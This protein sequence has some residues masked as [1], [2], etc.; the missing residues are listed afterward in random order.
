MTPLHASGR[1]PEHRLRRLGCGLLL[2]LAFLV[3]ARMPAQAPGRRPRGQGEFRPPTPAF[4][5]DVPAHDAD[6]L[7]A[8]PTD[9]SVV[10]SLRV[11][12][13]GDVVV[14]HRPQGHPN[15]TRAVARG[16]EPW[17]PCEILL[18]GLA[19]NVRHE[20][21]V[22]LAAQGAEPR[23]VAEGGFHT[24]R[25]RGSPFA[26][27]VQADSH[28]DF[29]IL[30]DRYARSL[31][32]AV[33]SRPDFHVDLGDTFM[34]DKHA[35]HEDA[36]PM[37]QAQRYWLGIV[38]RHAPVFLV[39]GNHD[40]ESPGR[41]GDGDAMR[42][43][44]HGW[45]T[46]HFPNPIPN[47]FYSGNTQRHPRMGWP[48]DYYAW[49][50]G[51]AL[52]VALDPFW[53]S[54]RPGRGASDGWARTLGRDQYEWLRGLLATNGSAHVF[55]FIH[56]LVGGLGKDARG[57]AEASRWL[58]WGGEDPAGG[59]GFAER[60]KGWEAPIHELLRRRRRVVVFH[61]HDH[62]FARQ[63]RD[64]VIYQM[65][66][67]PGHRRGATQSARDYGYESGTL[68][69]GSGILRVRVKPASFHLDFVGVD[70]AVLRTEQVPA[71]P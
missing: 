3:P 30:T 41:G 34:T 44:S 4:Q 32:N 29:G 59:P 16:I 36:A 23:V 20:Y 53:Y 2:V 12:T 28:L 8:R 19:S 49:T 61:G 35:W 24:A 6:V 48:Q 58:E 9:R 15:W 64:G 21:R 65:V 18:E 22:A 68:L 67:Q 47:A 25:P 63:E 27:T 43:W 31:S 14:E 33:A 50:W 39:L 66:P 11:A 13:A 62:F 57:G 60:R 10:L 7:L 40:G 56:H 70:G 55:V 37:Y 46:R 42:E 45:R 17:A 5:T 71:A 69:P 52:F 38:G 54:Q 1:L 51:D 26:F